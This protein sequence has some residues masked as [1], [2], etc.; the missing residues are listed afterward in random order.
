M[1]NPGDYSGSMTAQFERFPDEKRRSPRIDG[2]GI[3][4]EY[5]PEGS[6]ASAI[7]STIKN[8]CIHG[9]CIYMPEVIEV[10][11]TINMKI[12][13]PGSDIPIPAKGVI[14]WY[15]AGGKADCYNVGI[16]F[17]KISEEDQKKLSGYIE[18]N[19]K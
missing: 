7:K 9:I 17:E 19:L 3:K 8:I 5:F 2:A 16:E 4:V 13:L 18:A 15:G 12:F 11:E 1:R 6:K 14:V 10:T